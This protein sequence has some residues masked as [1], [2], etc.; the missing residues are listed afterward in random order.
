MGS[1]DLR[2]IQTPCPRNGQGVRIS[3]LNTTAGFR[4]TQT[5][6]TPSDHAF[7]AIHTPFKLNAHSS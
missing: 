2:K 3:A 7:A 4:S 5:L 1:K 6:R